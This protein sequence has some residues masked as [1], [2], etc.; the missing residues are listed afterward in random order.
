MKCSPELE[1]IDKTVEGKNCESP[2]LKLWKVG[3][4]KYSIRRVVCKT[5]T[6]PVGYP[7]VSRDKI[8]SGQ[9]P[10]R[11]TLGHVLVRNPLNISH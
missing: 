2:M 3:W 9:L 6:V 8:L 10:T 1:K 7:D 5:F 4:Q 11:W